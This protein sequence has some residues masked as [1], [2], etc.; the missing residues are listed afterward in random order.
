MPPDGIK[1][2]LPV[3][4]RLAKIK[5]QRDSELR[6]ILEGADKRKI[7][8]IG[9]CSADNEDAVCDYVSQLGNLVKEVSD[10]L[11]IIPRIYTAKPRTKGG[12]YMG[13]Q[14]TQEGFLNLRRMHI[15]AAIE[16]G[17]TAADEL[18]YPDNYAYLDDIL[19]YTTVGARS[20]ENQQHRLVASGLDIPV[21]F[22]NPISGDLTALLNSIAAAQT[23]NE[24]K[25]GEFEVKT[26][27][28]PYAHAVLRG[29]A[30]APNYTDATAF[31][32]QYR[33]SRLKNPAI[34]IDAAHGN[35]GKDADRQI[36]I[37][38]E[39]MVCKAVKGVMIE[40]YLEDGVQ[41]EDGKIYGKSITDPCIGW[42]KTEKLILELAKTPII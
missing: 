13:M 8:I 42:I 18:L 41:P 7:I 29:G 35:S 30:N 14:H 6:A 32:E 10:K 3:P 37:A 15:R 16:S 28:N 11:F 23:P 4:S 26:S 17:L 25:Y 19:T 31:F 22:K 21:G 38:R 24:F 1:A 39:V 36:D 5:A 34:I 27:G 9:P 12:G 2:L 20:C 33:K 40:S